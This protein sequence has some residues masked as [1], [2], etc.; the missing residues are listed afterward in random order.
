MQLTEAEI[1]DMI[2]EAFADFYVKIYAEAYDGGPKPRGTWEERAA[3]AIA[4]KLRDGVVWE[5]EGNNRDGWPWI[6]SNKSRA[7]LAEAFKKLEDG[8]AFHVVFTVRE[9]KDADS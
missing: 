2:S 5:G 9:E 8:Q 3:R 4:E 1:A 6:D 7:D